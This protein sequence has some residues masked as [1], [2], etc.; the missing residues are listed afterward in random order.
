[1]LPYLVHSQPFCRIRLQETLKQGFKFF[2]EF[3]SPRLLLEGILCLHNHLMEVAHVI[4]FEGH[5]S[6]EHSIEAHTE[7][8]YIRSET[9]VP[10]TIRLASKKYLW[11]YIGWRPTLFCHHI[12]LRLCQELADSEVTQFE[13]HTSLTILMI[14]SISDIKE[15]V[16]KF[17]I[18][19]DNPFTMA[20][21]N[22]GCGL[23]E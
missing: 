18:P 2:G 13:S 3:L 1:M 9:F 15:H 10:T 11:C 20:I 12:I 5:C 6:K 7:T 22:S 17:Y 8:P 4:R 21:M 14:S 16:V 19:V 23:A